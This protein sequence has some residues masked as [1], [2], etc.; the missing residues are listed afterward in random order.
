M[1]WPIAVVRDNARSPAMRTGMERGIEI[2]ATN[3][4]ASGPPRNRKVGGN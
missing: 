1:R 3:K 2:E 4:G